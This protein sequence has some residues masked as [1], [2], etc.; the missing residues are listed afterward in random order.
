MH[1]AVAFD[2]RM[3]EL[4]RL[5]LAAIVER[6]LPLK[7]TSDSAL[8]RLGMLGPI[9]AKRRG[10]RGVGA[11]ELCML[12]GTVTGATGKSSAC[13]LIAASR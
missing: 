5:T 6:L 2:A 11:V 13:R 3:T 4:E 7:D 9:S 10:L 1:S 8:S 12:P